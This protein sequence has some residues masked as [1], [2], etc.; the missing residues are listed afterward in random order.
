MLAPAAYR[1]Q[2]P[3]SNILIAAL[4]FP[5][6]PKH[7]KTE[8]V[9]TWSSTYHVPG[10]EITAVDKKLRS[11]LLQSLE[12]HGELRDDQEAIEASLLPSGH[13]TYRSWG[14]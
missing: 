10:L 13:M 2:S 7:H 4:R 11:L 12:L 1:T 3:P 6:G 5:L 9:N 14:E 8:R